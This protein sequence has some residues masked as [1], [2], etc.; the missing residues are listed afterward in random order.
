MLALDAKGKHVDIETFFSIQQYI[1]KEAYLLNNEK[2]DEWYNSLEEDLI[3]WAPLRENILRRNRTPEITTFRVPL[4]EES[5]DSI[6]MRLRRNDSGMCWTEDPPTRQVTAIS[7]LEVFHTDKVD[8]FEVHTVFTL[9]RSRFERDDSTLMGR[10]KDIW[11]KVGNDY[12][13]SGRLILLQQSTLLTK[14]LNV[15]M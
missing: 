13:L 4:F 15:F 10:R 7:N 14:N 8:E 1:N 12:R 3:Y 6:A 9:Y 11:R 5:K 2:L